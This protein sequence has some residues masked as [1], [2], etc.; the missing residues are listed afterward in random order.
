MAFVSKMKLLKLSL[1]IA[2]LPQFSIFFSS[3]V[4]NGTKTPFVLV[5]TI[6]KKFSDLPEMRRCKRRHRPQL[7]NQILLYYYNYYFTHNLFR[8]LHHVYNIFI[9]KLIQLVM[10]AWLKLMTV[11]SSVFCSKRVDLVEGGKLLITHEDL[12]WRAGLFRSSSSNLTA[13][14]RVTFYI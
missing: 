9:K 7:N 1:K 11:F 10:K 3:I 4:I 13:L 12:T 14:S 8:L 2:W 5:G 6:L